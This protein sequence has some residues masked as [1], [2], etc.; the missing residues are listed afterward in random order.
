M[1]SNLKN[2]IYPLVNEAQGND[3]YRPG[4]LLF[5]LHRITWTPNGSTAVTVDLNSAFGKGNVDSSSL[6]GVMVMTSRGTAVTFGASVA[7][8]S[9]DSGKITV[10]LNANTTYSTETTM[11]IL[12]VGTEMPVTAISLS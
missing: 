10:S 12:V 4:S 9:S 11:W 1:A 8:H 3:A 6:L 7:Q 2:T 5:E